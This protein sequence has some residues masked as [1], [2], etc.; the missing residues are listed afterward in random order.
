MCV[1]SYIIFGENM[2]NL[3]KGSVGRQKRRW[4]IMKDIEEGVCYNSR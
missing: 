1:L 2:C 3:V 4:N